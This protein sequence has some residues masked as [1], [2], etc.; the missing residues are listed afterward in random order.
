MTAAELD[1]LHTVSQRYPTPPALTRYAVAAGL[2]GR[3]DEA[4]RSLK[5][6]CRVHLPRHCDDT[7]KRW[8]N[9][10]EQHPMLAAISFPQTPQR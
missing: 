7:R 8:A 9:L 6:L 5:S 4:S 1:W 10:V 2:N 3:A